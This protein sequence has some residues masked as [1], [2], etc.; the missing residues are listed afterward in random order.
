MS[1]RW[2]RRLLP[3]R[4]RRPRHRAS[5]QEHRLPIDSAA[6]EAVAKLDGRA[7]AAE[8][9]AEL[10]PHVEAVGR[11]FDGLVSEREERLSNDPDILR[12]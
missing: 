9:L 3:W 2:R 8:L 5:R 12:S 10:A 6:L 1:T 4:S 7:S 11:L